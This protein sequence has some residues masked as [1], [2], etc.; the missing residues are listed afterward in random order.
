MA[1]TAGVGAVGEALEVAAL[2]H[3]YKDRVA[4]EDV[5]FTLSGGV[6]ALLGVNGAGK[7][8]LLTAVAGGRA[9]SAGEVR[10]N[11]ND[12]YDRR[13]RNAALRS[14]ALM[15]QAA[16]FPG[17]MTALE[18]VEYLAWTRGVSSRSAP[19]LAREALETV[20]LGERADTKVRA[21][22][23]GMVRRVALAQAI[24]SRPDVLLLDE[25]STGLDPAQRRTM[26]ELISEL[27]TTVLLS[28]HVMEDVT[29]VAQR[30]LVLSDGRL[31]FDGTV[32]ELRAHAPER[33]D[34]ARA[35][36]AGFLRIVIDRPG[37]R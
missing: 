15:P 6:T 17:N 36:E 27:G 1:P 26:V 4:L 37:P 9:P 12:P 14:V 20:R 33:T 11:G 13:Q 2:G 28:S 24:A 7:T 10:V 21:L 16:T 5:S 8:T 31:V 34:P 23:G 22:S 19:R 18:V 30:V 35:A 29:D 3:R 32:P 25:P